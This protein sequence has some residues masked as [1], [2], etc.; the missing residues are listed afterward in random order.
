[1]LN[2]TVEELK[3]IMKE[4]KPFYD[5]VLEAKGSFVGSGALNRSDLY[6]QARNE[7]LLRKN[8]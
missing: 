5:I 6:N 4:N 8:A 1:M 3:A 7:L 2:K